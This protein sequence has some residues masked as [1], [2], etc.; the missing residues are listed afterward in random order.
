MSWKPT[1]YDTAARR[2]QMILDFLLANPGALMPNIRAW[3][4]AHGDTGHAS[5]TIRTMA[6]WSELRF[7]GES[8]RRRYFALT[9][10]TR[11]AE[12]SIAMREANLAAANALKK[13]DAE[14]RAPA[15]YAGRYIHK[16]GKHPI[17]NQ[18]GQGACR[19]S[20]HVNCGGI[21]A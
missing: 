2:R 15:S 1:S 5:N 6:D 8:H 3:L 14:T 13:R 18:G 21:H 20:V 11:S 4:A 9:E 19:A 10:T 17:P 16:P 12:E 7:D